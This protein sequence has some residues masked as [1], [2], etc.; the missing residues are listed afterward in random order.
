ARDL[1]RGHLPDA[2]D[3]AIVELHIADG[4]RRGLFP[5]PVSEI[6]GEMTRV[7]MHIIDPEI[8]VIGPFIVIPP[9]ERQQEIVFL[10]KLQLLSRDIRLL[11]IRDP[12]ILLR[13]TIDRLIV[14]RIS[15]AYKILPFLVLET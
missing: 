7:F 6:P 4:A 15:A 2:I 8:I 3:A 5:P 9:F 13:E 14:D 12:H 10:Y 11:L 1:A